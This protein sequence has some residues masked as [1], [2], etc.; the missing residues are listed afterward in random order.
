MEKRFNPEQLNKL[1]NPVRR[2]A[3]PPEKLLGLL[4]IRES[5]TVLDLGAGTGYFTIPASQLCQ[6]VYAL[7]AEPQMLQFLK[8]KLAEQAVTNVVTVEGEIE[9][10]PLEE[11]LAE[12]VIASF[13]MHEVEPLQD[14]LKEINRVLKPGGN[15]LCIEWE[16]KPMEQGPPLHH[17]L[18]SN[19]LAKSFEE[20]GFSVEELMFPTE[21][22]YVIIARK[23]H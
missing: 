7:D 6:K 11:Q 15:V 5:D 8:G 3:L 12:H 17:R 19:E 21:Q 13:V 9:Q 22:H 14:G 10:I 23:I 1:D 18:Y 20:Y 16:K 4:N 2:K